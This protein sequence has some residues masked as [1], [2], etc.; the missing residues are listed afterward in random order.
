MTDLR[1]E[2]T[3]LAA[4]LLG[5]LERLDIEALS[6]LTPWAEAG[7]E[8][9]EVELPTDRAEALLR[10]AR[11]VIATTEAAVAALQLGLPAEPQGPGEPA[12]GAGE[13]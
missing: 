6:R 7:W 1:C 9:I 10:V 13:S 3:E 12:E 11:D 2:S 5:P 8:I 4:L